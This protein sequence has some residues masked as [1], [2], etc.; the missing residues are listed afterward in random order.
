MAW[1]FMG[2]HPPQVRIWL[3]CLRK[4]G[5]PVAREGDYRA[6]MAGA[7]HRRRRRRARAGD[8]NR[9]EQTSAIAATANSRFMFI[10]VLS[11][12]EGRV[13]SRQIAGR[14]M[15]RSSGED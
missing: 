6:R 4:M 14:E 2:T 7:A 15:R 10:S 8:D 13:R 1:L 11:M 3:P 5:S 9:I 12:T